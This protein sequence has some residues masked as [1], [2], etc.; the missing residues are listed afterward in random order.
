MTIK[1]RLS[2]IDKQNIRSCYKLAEYSGESI[3]NIL[4]IDL[5]PIGIPVVTILPQLK[6]LQELVAVIYGHHT[7]NTDYSSSRKQIQESRT[8]PETRYIVM[9][10]LK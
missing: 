2:G 9:N 7:E 5:P 10:Y 1:R 4:A 8:P 3:Q 6:L